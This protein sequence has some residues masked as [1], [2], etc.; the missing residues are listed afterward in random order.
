MNQD[1]RALILERCKYLPF[2]IGGQIATLD[3]N[4]VDYEVRQQALRLGSLVP[5]RLHTDYELL[6]VRLKQL[7]VLTETAEIELELNDLSISTDVEVLSFERGELPDEFVEQNIDSLEIAQAT[8]GVPSRSEDAPEVILEARLLLQRITASEI[9]MLRATLA[10]FAG[11]IED[12]F[13]PDVAG[14]ESVPELLCDSRRTAARAVQYLDIAFDERLT[15][16]P[17]EVADF[18][19]CFGPLNTGLIDLSV[20]VQLKLGID[21][22]IDNSLLLCAQRIARWRSCVELFLIGSQT[23]NE[24][25]QLVLP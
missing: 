6:Q 7:L 18:V 23:V 10:Q 16:F 4:L 19:E 1:L 5:Q 15:E 22:L 3:A 11:R 17:F 8:E 24:F 25:E 14:F 2:V 9:E 20:S 21:A 13:I 12:G